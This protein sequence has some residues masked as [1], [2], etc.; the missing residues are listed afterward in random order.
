MNKQLQ[1]QRRRFLKQMS[2]L[3]G[4]SLLASQS[5]LQLISTALAADYNSISNYKSLV[6]IF[7]FGGNDAFNMFI[8]Y[9]NAAYQNYAN[10]RQ[11]MA[12]AQNTLLPVSNGQ[13]AF[14]P[15]MPKLRNLY[16]GNKLALVSNLGNLIEPVTRQQYLDYENGMGNIQL[17]RGL[18]SHSD[19]QEIWQTNLMPEAGTSHSGW[20]GR[21]ADLLR[22][23]N[24]FPF[25]FTLNGN[26]AWQASDRPE[27]SQFSLASGGISNFFFL[28]QTS[29]GW[30]EKR[31]DLASAWEAIF[32][33]NN[34][35]ALKQQATESLLRTK[36]NISEL[37]NAL[38]Q[39]PNIQTPYD[40]QN[41]LA[42]QLR[43]AA[44]LISVREILGMKRQIFFVGLGG[45]DTHG[46]QLED[47]TALLTNLDNAMDSFYQT[48]VE[49]GMA[50]SVTAFT[51]SEFGRTLTSNG[52]GTDHAWGTHGLAMGGNVDGGQIHG[53]LPIL[54]IGGPDD[55]GD[56]GRIIPKY[57]VDQYG[58]TLAK[59]MNVNDSDLLTVF[60][61][62][63]NFAVQDLG[64]MKS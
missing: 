57:S 26:N 16:N 54:E 47:H 7:L 24:H 18:F 12:I 43:M 20:G 23:A 32:A 50:D 39:T 55:A 49:L 4:T 33:T 51:A 53:E 37:Q 22:D 61:N 5:K 48:T 59:W 42:S 14:H 35:H 63:G 19:Q 56:D 25:S 10:I 9:E 6:C 27:T 29:D 44:K 2:L 13:H 30:P 34:T 38:A 60:P 11:N 41:E 17:P 64:F 21:I 31:S 15:S 3:G 62:L 36:V 52:D 46:N 28:T 40:D 8:P 58:A 1:R 45:W